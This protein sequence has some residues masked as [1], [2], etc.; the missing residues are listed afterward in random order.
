M[1]DPGTL[2]VYAVSTGFALTVDVGVY[3]VV[4]FAAAERPRGALRFALEI[5]VAHSVF[6]V[7]GALSAVALGRTLGNDFVVDALSA[8]A[9]SIVR[10][11]AFRRARAG[12]PLDPAATREASVP[13][14]AAATAAT[15]ATSVIGW[16]TAFALSFDALLV[17]PGASEF[18]G[19]APAQTRMFA[20]TLVGASILAFS[21]LYATFARRLRDLIRGGRSGETARG[22][23]LSIAGAAELVVFSVFLCDAVSRMLE[24]TPLGRPTAELAPAAAG[25]TL[26]IALFAFA[27]RSSSESPKPNSDE[28]AT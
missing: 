17:A 14:I 28:A 12:A 20:L 16:F 19:N 8:I 25:V 1:L 11:R 23:A 5:A 7:L 10:R 15:S 24:H 13:P 21:W 9:L 2:A 27:R 22:R 6:L 4:H 18:L 26:G 3:A